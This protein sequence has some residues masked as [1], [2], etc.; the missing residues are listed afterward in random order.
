MPAYA[1]TLPNRP[2]SEWEP[3]FTP[4]GAGEDECQRN[5]CQKCANLEPYHGHLNKVAYLTAKFASEMF[6]ADSVESKSAHQWGY[7]TGLW[8]DLG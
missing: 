2:P 3:L 8:H 7:L 4:F 1:H 5:N 6:P